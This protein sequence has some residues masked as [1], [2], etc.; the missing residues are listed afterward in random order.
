MAFIDEIKIYAKA[1]KGGDG[2]VRWRHEKYREFG[3]PSGG[4]GGRGGDVYARAVRDVHLLSKYR[5]KKEFVAENAENG[6][7]NNLHGADG[8]D[9][10]IELPIGSIITNLSN[11]NKIS[12]NTEGERIRILKGGNGGYGNEHFKSSTNTQPKEFT[13]GKEGEEAEF[14]IEVE[15]IADI[16][17]IGL[18]NAG[19]TSLLNSLTRA[20]GKI[21]EYPFT[22]LEPN[23]GEYFGYIISDIPGLIEGAASGKGLGHKFLRHIRR[24]KILVHLI[25]LENEDLI[26]TYKIVRKELKEFDKELLN[27]KEIVVL[28]KT[29]LFN[30]DGSIERLKESIKK[31]IDTVYSVSILDDESIKFFGDQLLRNLKELG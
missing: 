3:G 7:K 25:S 6:M 26:K 11:Q 23:L 10:D 4:D 13:E 8:K 16:G 29:D 14:Y 31:E 17:L 20:K 21:G 5:T 2:V 18:P 27:K 19:K 15:L 30:N 22:T 12:L 1:G 24:T 28:T 9:L